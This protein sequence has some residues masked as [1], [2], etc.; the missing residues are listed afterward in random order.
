M[1][2]GNDKFVYSKIFI[3]LAIFYCHYK[4]LYLDKGKV[5][6]INKR[7]SIGNQ[8]LIFLYPREKE[9]YL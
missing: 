8:I 4:Y 5:F 1:I 9:G 3:C 7:F 2:Y 6:P